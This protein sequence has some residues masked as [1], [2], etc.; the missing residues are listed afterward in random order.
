MSLDGQRA[1]VVLDA[2]IHSDEGGDAQI[3]RE[4]VQ[5]IRQERQLVRR[6]GDTGIA[7]DSRPTKEIPWNTKTRPCAAALR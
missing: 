1:T 7:D 4:S 6:A 2:A 5:L 3:V